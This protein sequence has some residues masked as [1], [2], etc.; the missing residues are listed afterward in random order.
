MGYKR[1]T[2]TVRTSAFLNDLGFSP[3]DPPN[4]ALVVQTNES[5]PDQEDTLVWRAAQ[6]QLWRGDRHGDL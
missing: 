6:S 4:A 5:A 1:L 2:G 3:R